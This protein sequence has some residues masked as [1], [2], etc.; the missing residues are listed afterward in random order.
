MLCLN[1]RMPTRNKL[2]GASALQ[3]ESR[4]KSQRSGKAGRVA[5]K[6]KAARSNKATGG[7][8]AR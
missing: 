2:S 5:G 7:K 8:L 6:G 3:K 4:L 1:T